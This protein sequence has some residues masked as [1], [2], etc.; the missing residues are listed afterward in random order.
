MQTGVKNYS[1]MEF[2]GKNDWPILVIAKI[3]Y[4]DYKVFAAAKA[5]SVDGVNLKSPYY[6]HKEC[7]T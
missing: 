6:S 7:S 2:C 4:P 5:I 1:D 3:N